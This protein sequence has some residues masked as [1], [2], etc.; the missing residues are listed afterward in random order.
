MLISG[1][2]T[3]GSMALLEAFIGGPVQIF[4][5]LR[6]WRRRYI[7]LQNT[8]HTDH[9]FSQ[10]IFCM[11]KD[12]HIC[13]HSIISTAFRLWRRSVSL[14]IQDSGNSNISP[15]SIFYQVHE[16]PTILLAGCQHLVGKY[17]GID[18][19]SHRRR[20]DSCDS[21]VSTLGT[22]KWHCPGQV[23]ESD[24]PADLVLRR[25]RCYYVHIR[26]YNSANLC[27]Y[28]KPDLAR[29]VFNSP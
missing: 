6:I 18:P 21:F 22:E 27:D 15:Y 25:D 16:A 8:C 5:A 29:I 11:W 12:D 1:V 23:E 20:C 10:Q 13:H 2:W 26:N 19:R 3:L 14:L 9:I 24:P 7:Q 17:C 28:V 4:F